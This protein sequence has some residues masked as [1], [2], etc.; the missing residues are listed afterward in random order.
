MF[1]SYLYKELFSIDSDFMLTKLHTG[2]EYNVLSLLYV[3]ERE[4]IHFYLTS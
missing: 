4:C 1:K 3:L 2:I